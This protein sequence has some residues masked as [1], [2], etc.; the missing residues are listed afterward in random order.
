MCDDVDVDC[1]GLIAASRFLELPGP[2]LRCARDRGHRHQLQGHDAET[3]RGQ[4]TEHDEPPESEEPEH[5]PG[6]YVPPLVDLRIVDVYSVTPG[7]I[8]A[9]DLLRQREYQLPPALREGLARKAD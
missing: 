4:V 7:C 2:T 8:Y 3:H 5:D 6:C 9:G 1:D